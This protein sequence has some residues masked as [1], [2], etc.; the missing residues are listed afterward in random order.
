[1]R[2][3]IL[4]AGRQGFVAKNEDAFAVVGYDR[5]AIPEYAGVWEWGDLQL[6][7]CCPF[8]GCCCGMHFKEALNPWHC[9][10]YDTLTDFD[11]GGD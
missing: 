6:E 11:D 5:D 10:G 8:S 1:M 9:L 3:I 2:S 7:G 4:R